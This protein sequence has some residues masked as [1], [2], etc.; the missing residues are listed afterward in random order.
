[1]KDF[2][3]E[4]L[5]EIKSVN[6]KELDYECISEETIEYSKTI[7]DFKKEAYEKIIIERKMK[8]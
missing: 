4:Y 6:K 7:K 3:N 5:N 2:K 1:M 8:Y